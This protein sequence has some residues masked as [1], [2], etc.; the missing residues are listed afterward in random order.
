MLL[1][2]VTVRGRLVLFDTE[3]CETELRSEVLAYPE[4]LL[5]YPDDTSD[6]EIGET[7]GLIPLLGLV[8][9]TRCVHSSPQPR[10]LDLCAIGS[11]GVMGR[12]GGKSPGIVLACGTGF[13]FWFSWADSLGP[14]VA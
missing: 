8:S 9:C 6:M 10:D 14:S 11:K 13:L 5:A 2:G 4:E 3:I 12:S 1:L 7:V